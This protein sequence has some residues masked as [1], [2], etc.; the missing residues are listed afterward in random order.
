MQY[1]SRATTILRLGHY[2]STAVLLPYDYP[3]YY[4]YRICTVQLPYYC[5]TTT[6]RRPSYGRTDN[7]RRPHQ[8]R[9]INVLRPYYG[10]SPTVLLLNNNH[11]ITE[12][13]RATRRFPLYPSSSL[14]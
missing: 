13:S 10:R 12:C 11:N 7:V 6:R 1:N 14:I 9:S 8:Y 2:R 3:Y 4:Y 5:N